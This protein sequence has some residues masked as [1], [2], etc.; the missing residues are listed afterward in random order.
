MTA[1]RLRIL[2]ALALLAASAVNFLTVIVA[3]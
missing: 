1:D 3:S 2:V